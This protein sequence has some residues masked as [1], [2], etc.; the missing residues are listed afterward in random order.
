MFLTLL[1]GAAADV[2]M[3]YPPGSNNRLDEG[4]GNRN[5]NNRLMDTQNN[6][7]GGYG[8]GGDADNPADNLKYMVGS[9]LTMEWTS[10]HS[11]GSGNNQCDVII[12]TMCN[13]AEGLPPASY[14]AYPRGT[15]GVNGYCSGTD[16]GNTPEGNVLTTQ[17]TC[18]A[19]D[20]NQWVPLPGVGEGPIRDGV[21]NT[22]P[23]P[24][25]PDADTG[26]H[27]PGSFYNDC[28]MRERNKGLYTADQNVKNQQGAAA[29]RQN[30]NGDRSGQE[31]AEERDYYPY[32][33]PTGWRDVAILT[34]DLEGCQMRMDE[35]Q[36]VKEKNYCTN[37]TKNNKAECEASD[38]PYEPVGTKATWASM[39]C[40]GAVSVVS[41]L[42]ECIPPPECLAAPLQRDNHLGNIE[43]GKN[44][45]YTW[46]IP[47]NL[48]I[49]GVEDATNCIVRLRYNI[50]TADTKT[51]SDKTKI[52]EADCIAEKDDAGSAVNVWSNYYTDASYNDLVKNVQQNGQDAKA[53]G[54]TD[55][56][57]LQTDP[58]T[59]M[60][61]F[62]QDTGGTDSL[63][64]MA[65]NTNQY[66]RTFQDRS[67]T[68]TVQSRPAAIGL[69]TEIYN[70]NVRGKRGNIV[71]TYPAT[72]YDFC[73]TDLVC[74]SEDMI[75][76]Q[77]T[78]NDN[79]NNNGNNNGEGTNNEDRSNI[80]EQ[81]TAGH[82]SPQN[83]E[84]GS[85]FDTAWEWNPDTT[86]EFGGGRDEDEL[87]HQFALVKQ[88]G[89][90][91]NPNNDQDANNCQKLNAASA[92]VDF[93]LLKLK[94][95]F[96]QFYS[97]RNNNFSNRAQ[98]ATITVLEET[99][100]TP[101]MPENVT[102]VPIETDDENKAAIG[103]YWEAPGMGSTA[104]GFDG[105]EY[106]N[107]YQSSTA[108][109]DYQV[110]YSVDGGETWISAG[111]K[112]SGQVFKCSITDLPAGTTVGVIVQAGGTGGYG[113]YSDESF[114]ETKESQT[115]RECEATLRAQAEGSYVSPG[116]IVAIS[117]GVIAGCLLLAGLAF[118]AKRR[119]PPP[120]PGGK[121][122]Y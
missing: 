87:T 36:N 106:P 39:P 2:Y 118:V 55:P 97:T 85:M 114:V 33:H 54:A 27:E 65:V 107:T 117:F 69:A 28:Q 29:T 17:T 73:P 1:A 81:E 108:V 90:D 42:E 93:G 70:L 4:G 61:G 121:A 53:N 94:P 89:C 62:L 10:Q 23:D 72:E 82:A 48:G 32:W 111:A 11:C 98:K 49:N 96:Y 86:A 58:D 56:G 44:V 60:G 76:F 16:D 9:Y 112:C 34:N 105:L 41:G 19:V 103:C 57:L 120:P 59:S 8:Y 35:S 26:I 64:E 67:H 12:Q 38:D 15:N 91:V 31:C 25:A 74:G 24:N 101:G 13:A 78:G 100:V 116:V 14:V 102:C 80:V 68:F 110:S 50:T 5:N 18:E 3:Q 95:G 109:V 71:Q 83:Y 22:S 122:G 119:Q 63:L 104:V 45:V 75:H 7:K 115:S 47:G 88:T 51:C 52:T 84:Q 79:T 21:D 30:P 92:T 46:K 77:W 40:H 99:S 37:P 113:A 6:G 20:G 66:G 43:T